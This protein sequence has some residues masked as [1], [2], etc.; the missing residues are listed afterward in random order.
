V[1]PRLKAILFL[2]LVNVL[3]GL[4]FSTV[5]ALNAQFDLQFQGR[6][7]PE[8]WLFRISAAAFI[9]GSRFACALVLFH[10]F[11]PR[12]TRLVTRR[13][14]IAGSLIGLSFLVG[15]I[16]QTIGLAMIPASRSGFLTSLT[17]V[18]IPTLVAW[19]HGRYPP[20]RVFWGVCLS[21][22]GVSIL[23]GLLVWDE[24]GLHLAQDSLRA[25]TLGDTLTVIS[26]FFFSVQILSI[27]HFSQNLNPA[28]FTY[29]MFACITACAW[30]IFFL[31]RF[32]QPA[33]L[34]WNDYWLLASKPG[35]WSL[36]GLL[37]IFPSLLAFSWMNTY[38]PQVTAVQATVI[39]TLEPVFVTAWA[40]VLPGWFH[41][42][43]AL[44]MHQE[45]LT[46]PMLLGGLLILSANVLSLWPRG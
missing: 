35:F 31:C 40:L 8:G 7:D 34:P 45:S 2:V 27:D 26:T 42:L 41:R 29:G 39:Y 17:V 43:F 1:N 11:F 28:T 12:L 24:T 25:W 9:I 22:L 16:L 37:S 32:Y 46:L 15:L 18:I 10:A 21:L 33:V 23:T 13:E 14:F 3:W 6:V 30:L 36:I 4:S 5:K 19:T 38:Q 44:P 20:Q